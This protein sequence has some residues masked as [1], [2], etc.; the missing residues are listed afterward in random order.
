M[1]L[2]PLRDA[3]AGVWWTVGP[4]FYTEAILIDT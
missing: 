4:M 3:K 2:V 1:H